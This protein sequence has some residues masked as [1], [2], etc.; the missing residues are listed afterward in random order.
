MSDPI[1]Q[2]SSTAAVADFSEVERYKPTAQ[3]LALAGALFEAQPDSF[4]ALAASAGISPST[5][6]RIRS[7]PVRCAWILTKAYDAARSTIPLVYANIA[8]HAVSSGNP[9]WCRLFV[10]LFDERAKKTVVPST[11]NNQFNFLGNMSDEELKAFLDQTRA[12]LLG[13]K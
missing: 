13:S 12:R 3:D 8:R 6:A 11:Q 4:E 9:N 7:D 5:L 10:E 2:I 1:T